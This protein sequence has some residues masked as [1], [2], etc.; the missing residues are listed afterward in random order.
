MTVINYNLHEKL[1]RGV[2]SNGDANHF[3]INCVVHV[4][5]ESIKSCKLLEVGVSKYVAW[6]V[7]Y[8]HGISYIY[9]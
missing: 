6:H 2:V 4:Y 5:Q 1:W 9:V 3:E 8:L 7:P